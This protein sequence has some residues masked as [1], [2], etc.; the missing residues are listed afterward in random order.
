MP[1]PFSSI[2]VPS[3]PSAFLQPVTQLAPGEC[4][5]CGVYQDR[6]PLGGVAL[7]TWPICYAD[8]SASQSQGT[9]SV[10]HYS[11][12]WLVA[13]LNCSACVEKGGGATATTY[14]DGS[15]E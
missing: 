10:A 5:E 11:P 14:S 6:F 15:S 7:S 3:L 4:R 1:P 9:P 13:R 2:P 12:N 8:L